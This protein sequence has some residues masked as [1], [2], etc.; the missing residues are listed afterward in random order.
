M[1][2]NKT[3]KKY[4]SPLGLWALSFGCSVGWGAFVMPGTTFLPIAGPVGTALGI[5]IGG[6]IML[7]IGKN[8]YYLIKRYP[9]SGGT[10]IYAKNVL[11]HDHGFLSAWFLLLAYIVIIW[12]N[13]TALA[14][15]GRNLL[16]DMFM[17]GFHYQLAGYDIYF[18]EILA[19]I[20]VMA[21]CCAICVFRKSLAAWVQILM[22]LILIGGIVVCFVVA[23][24][25][26]GG[27]STYTPA[28]STISKSNPAVQIVSIVALMPWAYVGF[29]SV[30]HSAEELKF[31]QKKVF[32][33]L[34]ISLITAALAYTL[35]S[36]LAVN[37]L[38][39]GYSNWAEYIADIGN[40]SGKEALPTFY[41]V[42]RAM[43]TAGLVI[44]GVT[45][46][47][48][49]ITG[50]IGNLIAS[51]R[52]VYAISRD[53]IMPKWFSK[54]NK[55]GNP[56]A[57]IIAISAVSMI[58]PFFGRTAISWIVDVTT[59]GG[60]I[61]YCYT[62]AAALKEAY[63]EKNR[64][65]M[66]SGGAGV[67]FSVLFALYFLIPNI[68]AVSTLAT[69]SYLI[70]TVWSI[71]GLVF[72]R[73]VFVR[74][75]KHKYGK[76]IVVWIVLLFLIMFTSIVWMQQANSKAINAVQD[77]ITEQFRDHVEEHHSDELK[78]QEA[79]IEDSVE[80]QMQK[81]NL[82]LL[83]NNLLR[84]GMIVFAVMILFMVYSLMTK[85]QREFERV[86]EMAYKDEL[87]GI[88][89]KHAY[90][91]MKKTLNE[92]IKVGEVTELAIAVCD[93][94]GLKTIN[95]TKGH[96]EGDRYIREACCI[97]CNTFAHSPVY[98]IGGDEFV[99]ILRGR[100]FEHR[101]NLL[102]QLDQ[103]NTAKAATDGAIIAYG[104]ADYEPGFD[105][106]VETVFSRADVAM[107]RKKK[108]LKNSASSPKGE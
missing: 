69:E 22:A 89:N 71:I 36:L 79:M 39:E 66:I 33:I 74:D 46:L 108:E 88:G 73:K 106:T 38:P 53:D 75:T 103:S 86:E 45:V 56:Y 5:I 61:I 101:E 62:S 96:A 21:I 4:L 1:E 63:N 54:T 77:S 85:R 49:I 82:T 32:A 72:F 25:K 42:S 59:V 98:R 29:E 80:S 68:S 30:S 50:I 90:S 105:K 55:D 93:L 41:A 52:V 34:L 47:G 92:E 64:N 70:L 94:N 104:A 35:L 8:Y 26:N 48:G 20:G 43:G 9:D 57:A 6:L 2:E 76:S 37:S 107:Y 18:G 102:A 81:L 87:T 3:L 11:G 97:I 10:Y 95:D 51:S 7:I 23:A 24:V 91:R 60:T 15:I 65:M 14:L 28:F 44:L 67:L 78:E 58:I 31:K 84:I 100:D 19:A 83:R 40:L 99:V 17:F 12:A 13:L 27:T 16:G